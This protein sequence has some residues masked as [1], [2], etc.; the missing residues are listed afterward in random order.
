MQVKVI[1]RNRSSLLQWIL[2]FMLSIMLWILSLSDKPFKITATLPLSEPV[3]SQ[4][5]IVMDDLS[6]DSIQVTFTG[7]GIGVLRDQIFHDLEAVQ[8]NVSIIDLSQTF[9][10]TISRE[11]TENSVVFREN[12]F[13]TLSDVEFNPAS[14]EFTIDRKTVRDLPVSI[15]STSFIPERFY[16]SETSVS[17]VEVNGAE[18]IVNRLD[19]CYTVPVSPGSENP[20]AVI[21][22][23]DGVAYISPSSISAELVPPVQVITSLD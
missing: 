8:V 5:Y 4:E 2:A 23:P 22:K 16:W 21:V 10:L 19:S 9:P 14:I 15:T 7:N 11:F 6:R 1:I 3:I 13:S 18:S 20:L 12:R 17:T